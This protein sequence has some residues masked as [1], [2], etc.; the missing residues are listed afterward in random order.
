MRRMLGSASRWLY[1]GEPQT[2]QNARTLPG[3]DSYRCSKSWPCE[4]AKADASTGMLVATG[5]PWACRHWLQWHTWMAAKGPWMVKRMPPQRQ[6]P[7][8][9]RLMWFPSGQALAG[10]VGWSMGVQT[11]C[12]AC[13]FFGTR[14]KMAASIAAQKF[15]ANSWPS[16][17]ESLAAFNH[18]APAAPMLSAAALM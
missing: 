16:R 7:W 18:K 4:N 11:S 13:N 14:N 1:T 8:C 5:P 6:E 10:A 15:L 3:D 2:L 12:L 9:W 17:S